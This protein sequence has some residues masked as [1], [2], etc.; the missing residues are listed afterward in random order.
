[1]KKS[2]FHQIIGCLL[3][4]GEI[5]LANKVLV[6]SSDLAGLHIGDY[7]L[8]PDLSDHKKYLVLTPTG[9]FT[10][11]WVEFDNDPNNR[12]GRV[13]V[14]TTLEDHRLARDVS[15]VLYNEGYTNVGEFYEGGI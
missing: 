7:S 2:E 12:G 14:K 11:V 5:F 13:D 4:S 10:N 8:Q 1:M 6:K 15:K 9:E 3:C